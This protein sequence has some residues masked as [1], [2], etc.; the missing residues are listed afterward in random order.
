MNCKHK[1]RGH[2]DG[3]T[4]LLC[5]LQ[6]TPAEYAEFLTPAKPEPETPE[7]PA[8]QS[9]PKRTRKKKEATTHE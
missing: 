9:A 1:F 6:M 4:C 5:G 3:V 2:K 8:K 7:A